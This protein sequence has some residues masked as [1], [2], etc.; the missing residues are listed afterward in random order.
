VTGTD[1][2]LQGGVKIRKMIHV[3]T[4][5]GKKSVTEKMQSLLRK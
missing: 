3:V 5:D 2:C 4:N 1:D